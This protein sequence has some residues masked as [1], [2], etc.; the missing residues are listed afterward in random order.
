M[1]ASVMLV[2]GDMFDGPSDLIVLPC[3]TAGTV[4][5]EVA[6]RLSEYALPTPTA[7]MKFGEVKIMPFEGGEHIA[8]FVAFAASVHVAIS[9]AVQSIAGRVGAIEAIA[10]ALGEFSKQN[11]SVRSIS[12]P[13]LGSRVGRLDPEAIVAALKDGF[14]RSAHKHAVLNVHVL[15]KDVFHRLRGDKAAPAA[16]AKKTVRA[17]ISHT[18]ST[19]AAVE[20]VK[21]LALFLIDRGIQARLDQFNL[22]RGMD[23]PQWMCNELALADKVVI[24][25]DA[26]YKKKADGS[27]GGVG[28]ET[29][30]IQGD[31]LN[32]RPDS[33]KYQV[34][35]RTEKLNEGLPVYLKGKYAFHAGPRDESKAFRAELVREL[36]DLP[37]D[38]ERNATEFSA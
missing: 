38:A 17:F 13:L 12:V 37:P 26:A 23:L 14:L 31:M 35:V 10:V 21:E 7:G 16:E 3:S 33:T 24:V 27:L 29:R 22:R 32:L 18:S 19:D 9:A 28:W 2:L 1:A 15:D 6:R 4:M 11:P 36:L 30:I 5:G 34:V 20:W 8:Q 25:C